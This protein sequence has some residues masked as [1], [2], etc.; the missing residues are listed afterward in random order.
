[1]SDEARRARGRRD[2]QT[3][4]AA[5]R[6]DAAR[7]HAAGER[8]VCWLCNQPIDM[9]IVDHLDDEFYEPDHV[10][11]VSTHPELA[12][13]P[14]NLRDSHRGCNRERGNDMEGLG[15][16]WTSEDWEGLAYLGEQGDA[17]PSS[18]TEQAARTVPAPTPSEYRTDTTGYPDLFND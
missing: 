5:Q 9:T 10:F 11:P 14:D 2:V 4:V 3:A 12:A 6:A 1:M 16:G 7:R 13:D 18:H 15:L 17:A 8:V